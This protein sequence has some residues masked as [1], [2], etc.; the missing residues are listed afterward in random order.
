MKAVILLLGMMAVMS[1][2][3]WAFGSA[4]SSSGSGTTS[5]STTNTT[6]EFNAPDADVGTGGLRIAI[7]SAKNFNSTQ[8]QHLEKS[9]ALLEQIVNTEE[10]K[11]RVLHFTYQGQETYVQNQGL[12]NLQIYN[13]IMRAAEQLPQKTAIN[14]T[15]DLSVQL[16]TSSW[17]G[18]NVV[19]YTTAS[20]ST[21]YMN[22]YFYNS[23][24]PGDSAA[25]MIHEW[26]HKLGFEHDY[27]S[28][29]RRPYSVPYAI[30][31]IV[32]EMA[33]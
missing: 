8:L 31:N 18:R 13:L 30:G 11:Q 22:T 3:V 25:N 28:T 1:P 29:T 24:S 20:T 19:G 33:N 9:R 26:L 5:G 17:F 2:K 12:T 23:A 32:S 4:R 16:Y 6:V 21:I 27:N 14:Q 7:Q 15:M 10:F